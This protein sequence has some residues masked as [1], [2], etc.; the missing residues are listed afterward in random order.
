MKRARSL[1]GDPEMGGL[2]KKEKIVG[3]SA[4][5]SYPGKSCDSLSCKDKLPPNIPAHPEQPKRHDKLKSFVS[6][7]RPTSNKFEL[8]NSSKNLSCS[9]NLAQQFD[10][11]FQK[12]AYG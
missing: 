2:L 7:L 9:N 3:P 12:N 10:V 8:S 6:P 1:L 11:A 4:S 5:F